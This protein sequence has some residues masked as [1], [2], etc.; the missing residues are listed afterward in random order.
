MVLRRRRGRRRSARS[1]RRIMVGT[2]RLQI[3]LL[4][5]SKEKSYFEVLSRQRLV[6][7][8]REVRE[9]QDSNDEI[10]KRHG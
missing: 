5:R 1:W 9:V 6:E 7:K 10:V 3:M 4:L 8:V 2:R